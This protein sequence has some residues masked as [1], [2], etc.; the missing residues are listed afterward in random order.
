MVGRVEDIIKRKSVF[1]PKTESI[2]SCLYVDGN[3]PIGRKKIDDTR[4]KK[5]NCKSKDLKWKAGHGIQCSSEEFGHNDDPLQ[6]VSEK[7]FEHN[8]F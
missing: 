4:G 3:N 8:C 1:F 2:L 7:I 6:C 5:D